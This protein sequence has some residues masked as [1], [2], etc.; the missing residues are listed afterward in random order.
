MRDY[1]V[2][3]MAMVMVGRV[4]NE[5]VS[6]MVAGTRAGWS[7]QESTCFTSLLWSVCFFLSLAV[8][9]FGGGR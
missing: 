7:A 6:S 1:A 8:E 9:G 4:K 2:R 3:L 5:I